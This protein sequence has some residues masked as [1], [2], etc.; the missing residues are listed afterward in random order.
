MQLSGAASVAELRQA[1]VVVSGETYH[2]LRV[3][4]FEE[5]L[6]ELA[7]RRLTSSAH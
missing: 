4:G 1:D 6:N 3:R 5:T 2:W 7:R